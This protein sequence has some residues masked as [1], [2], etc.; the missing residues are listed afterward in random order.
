MNKNVGERNCAALAAYKSG[1]SD[2]APNSPGQIF[3][4]SAF[5]PPPNFTSPL[6]IVRGG[7]KLFVALHGRDVFAGYPVAA[8]F[9]DRRDEI[10][11]RR[12][13]GQFFPEG[14]RA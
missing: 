1:T 10:E 11:A 7:A 14:G 6:V 4:V 5:G 12:L 13:L 9:A 2:D 3:I 8:I